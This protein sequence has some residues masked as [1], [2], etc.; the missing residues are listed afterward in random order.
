MSVSCAS[1]PRFRH[2]DGDGRTLGRLQAPAVW[3]IVTQLIV[4]VLGEPRRA[5]QLTLSACP[6]FVTKPAP[7]THK[8]LRMLGVYDRPSDLFQDPALTGEWWLFIT[9][10]AT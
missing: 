6:G 8:D 1:G 5:V 3:R 9:Y 4:D 10:A 2:R 7:T